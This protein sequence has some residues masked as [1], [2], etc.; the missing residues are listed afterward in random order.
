MLRKGLTRVEVERLLGEPVTAS[1]RRE[2]GLTVS[3]LVFTMGDQ[4]ITAEFVDEVL[5]R[6]TIMSR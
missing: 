4:R 6:Y 5:I 2:G 3:T 1:D